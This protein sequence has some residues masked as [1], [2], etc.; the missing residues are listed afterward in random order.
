LQS[1][2]K[3]K[4]TVNKTNGQPTDWE[5]I[6]TN[7]TSNRGNI[8][9]IYIY[10]KRLITKKTKQPNQNMGYRAKLRIYNRGIWNG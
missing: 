1:F 7:P 3:S 9:P 4:D 6:F 10:L 8:Y 5:K 2:C